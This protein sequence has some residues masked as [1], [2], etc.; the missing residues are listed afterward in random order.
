MFDYYTQE[1]TGETK[2]YNEEE[3]TEAEIVEEAEGSE[4]NSL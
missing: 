1:N 3:V 2:S 4:R